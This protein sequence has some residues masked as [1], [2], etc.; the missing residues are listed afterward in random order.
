MSVGKLAALFVKSSLAFQKEGAGLHG[1]VGG[2]SE[3]DCDLYEQVLR[4]N[5]R[6]R[7]KKKIDC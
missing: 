4:T 3:Q 1:I 2:M 5:R 7:E 6:E